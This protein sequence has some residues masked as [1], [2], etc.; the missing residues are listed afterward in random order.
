MM[1]ITEI[2]ETPHCQGKYFLLHLTLLV[3]VGM[4]QLEFKQLIY[5][6]V[7]YLESPLE[8]S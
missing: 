6:N 5:D 1:S 3:A 8:S 7:I 4:W 2:T